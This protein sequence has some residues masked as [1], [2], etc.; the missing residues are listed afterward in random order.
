MSTFATLREDIQSW[1][2][3]SD[4]PDSIYKLATAQINRSLVVREMLADFSATTSGETVALPSGFIEFDHLYID[5]DPRVVLMAADQWQQS[6]HHRNSGQPA[7]YS[8]KDSVMVLNPVPDG[9]YSLAGRYY[10]EL[11]DFS[12]DADTNAVLVKYPEIYLFANLMF[13]YAWLEDAER[14]M[15]ATNNFLAVVDTANKKDIKVRYAGP[16][17]QRARA[18]A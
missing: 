15:K 8:I 9:S 6:A 13:V 7:T 16:V 14:E 12:A 2:L 3:R 1:S 4:Y 18:S 17:R 5:A 10:S 11:T